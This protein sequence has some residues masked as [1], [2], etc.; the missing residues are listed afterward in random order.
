[1]SFRDRA[2]ERHVEIFIGFGALV[3]VGIIMLLTQCRS[4]NMNEGF[5]VSRDYHPAYWS[6]VCTGSRRSR[7]CHPVYHPPRYSI[8]V[9]DGH[10]DEDTIYMG[11]DEWE[12]HPP[13][14]WMCLGNGPCPH[15]HDDAEG[16]R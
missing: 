1:M 14:G 13:G 15:P 12:Q 8:T 2:Y 5:I 16:G 6:T 9:A 7:T 10:H 11:H 4:S 3:L